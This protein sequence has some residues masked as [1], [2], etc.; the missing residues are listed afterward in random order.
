MEAAAQIGRQVVLKTASPGVI[1]KSDAGG[2]RLGVAGADS[3][4]TAYDDISTK[5][6]PDLT[7]SGSAAPGVELALLPLW[8][9]DGET[10]PG[11]P[12]GCVPYCQC[13]SVAPAAARACSRVR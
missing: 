2:V 5:L 1:H 13:R 9:C 4:L 12:A 7:V 3:L 10:V 8:V 11:V 6:G